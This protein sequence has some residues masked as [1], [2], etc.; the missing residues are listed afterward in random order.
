[1]D[2][3]NTDR[4]IASAIA[5]LP[6]HKP[7]AGFSARVMA[8]IA[9]AGAPLRWQEGVFEAVGLVITAWTAVLAFASAWFVCRN[10]ADIAAFFI[11]PG[12]V[13]LALNLL[14]AHAVLA[15]AKLTA[16]ASL[17]SELLSVAVGLPVWYEAPVAA[18]LCSAAIAALSKQ[19]RAPAH[20]A[21][22]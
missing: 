1:M 18:L 3:E 8:G 22:I 2:A 21:G 6:Y 16:I 11:Q 10:L 12:G 20:K 17:A 15:A 7:A 5:A 19:G 4:L 9:A 14:A 13:T